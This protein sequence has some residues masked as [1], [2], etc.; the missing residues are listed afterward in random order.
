MHKLRQVSKT[1][2]RII[3]LM[4]A[5][6]MAFLSPVASDDSLAQPPP[7]KTPIIIVTETPTETPTVTPT[8]SITPTPSSTPTSSQTPTPT[9][10]GTSTHTPTPTQTQTHTPTPTHTSTPTRTPT[11]QVTENPPQTATPKPTR[12]PKPAPNCQSTVEGYVLNMA[13]QQVAGATVRITSTGSSSQVLT[14]GGGHYA[15]GGLCAGSYTLQATLPNG[16]ATQAATANVTGQ[17]TVRLDLRVPAAATSTPVQSGPTSEPS[18]PTTGFSG[19]QLL[20]G[21]VLGLL[22]LLIAG[23]RR[24]LS[25]GQD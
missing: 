17:N 24:V 8:P 5:I 18:M 6:G 3:A 4:C 19:W 20:G 10:T 1:I 9:S 12:T 25:S 7:S 21:A 11:S 16:K 2:A 15:F 13:G 22:L 23:A 14:D